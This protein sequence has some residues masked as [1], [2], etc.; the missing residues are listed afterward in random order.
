MADKLTVEAWSLRKIAMD[1][2]DER[3]PDLIANAGD[4][5]GRGIDL[6]ITSGGQPLSL[7]GMTVY[8][9]WRHDNGNQDMTRFDVVDAAGGHVRVK[10]P[11]AMMHAGNVIARIAVY[12]SPK[13]P[14]T[15]S[16]DFR[17]LV[18]ESPIVE[19]R[20]MADESFSLF[21]KAI[22]EIGEFRA[23]AQAQ[24]SARQSAETQRKSA[25]DAR[26][27]AEQARA[28]AEGERATHE[29]NRVSSETE[30]KTAESV[31]STVFAAATKSIND[32]IAKA[33]K[34]ADAANAAAQSGTPGPQGPKGDPGPK[35]DRG[36]KGPK[37]DTGPKGQPDDGAAWD[38]YQTISMTK[39][40]SYGISGHRFQGM[41]SDGD[42]L[43]LMSH[44]SDTKP[45]TITK[46]K[47][48]TGAKVGSTQINLKGH[49]NSMVYLNG[50]LYASAAGNDGYYDYMGC[51]KCADMS[52]KTYK[53]PY[54]FWSIALADAGTGAHLAGLVADTHEWVV[55]SRENPDSWTMTPLRRFTG[56]DGS[57]IAQG[58]DADKDYL[59]H[60]LA[61]D[62]GRY[63]AT[64]VLAVMEWS[65]Y[66]RRLLSIKGC[67]DVELEDVCIPK[68]YDGPIYVNDIDGN[69][70]KGTLKSTL[71]PEYKTY[72]RSPWTGSP[73]QTI[74][75]EG[76][77]TEK[78]AS[79]S[80][81]VVKSFKVAP[82]VY[83]STLAAVI[84]E[85]VVNGCRFPVT[86]DA[87][88][89]KLSCTNF[90]LKGYK[91]VPFK[92]EWDRTSDSRQYG[93][94]LNSDS[95]VCDTSDDKTYYGAKDIAESGLI[96]KGLSMGSL[97]GI[98]GIAPG[99]TIKL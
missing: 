54:E 60:L 55:F 31:R 34:A 8:L 57:G 70:W 36:E 13:E 66:L 39:L 62:S 75:N 4:A 80:P 71:K 63:N 93:W 21:T 18:E 99:D 24:E 25:E 42:Y 64:N 58:C 26:R 91:Y 84:G 76:N 38:K 30:R 65:G 52:Y 6:K 67:G 78:L 11:P 48:A 82:F 92:L 88:N 15:G 87:S 12:V 61:Y 83:S 74:Y 90:Y 27:R 72:V 69:V 95:W 53:L 59:Y 14:I 35:G 40:G 28:S 73:I 44:E 97:I 77:G 32:V 1:N 98:V 3:I 45:T 2:A 17:I 33:N 94:E 41:A 68:G 37:G 51:I 81:R 49:Y 5:N 19:G 22:A 23:N 50:Y 16:R 56:Y 9:A 89:G 86:Y 10:Y 46:I 79:S 43:Y 7:A 96:P 20:A 29:T 47:I 85:A